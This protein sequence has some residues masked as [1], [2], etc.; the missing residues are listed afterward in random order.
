MSYSYATRC[1][2]PAQELW[3]DGSGKEGAE[4]QQPSSLFLPPTSRHQTSN[5]RVE[6][7]TGDADES[8]EPGSFGGEEADEGSTTRYWGSAE[9][10][11]AN[12]SELPAFL[13]PEA[14]AELGISYSMLFP[15][16]E[17]HSYPIKASLI[18]IS[19]LLPSTLL[20]RAEV[21]LWSRRMLTPEEFRVL[22]GSAFRLE[23][24]ALPKSELTGLYF[25]KHRPCWSVDYYSRQRK[26]KTIDFF[27]P[28]VKHSTLA[29]VLKCASACRL[30][31]PRRFEDVPSWIPEPD[32][33]TGGLPYRAGAAF[34]DSAV[35]KWVLLNRPRGDAP[36]S[37]SES[38]RLNP[39]GNRDV[40]GK[41]G[42]LAF[43]SPRKPGLSIP[44]AVSPSLT[45]DSCSESKVG[46]SPPLV[47]PEAQ[48]PVHGGGSGYPSGAEE[49]LYLPERLVSSDQQK[50]PQLLQQSPPIYQYSGPQQYSPSPGYYDE[51][52]PAPSNHLQIDGREGMPSQGPS[53][54]SSLVGP[55][56]QELPMVKSDHSIS[57]D[58]DWKKEAS[59]KGLAGDSPQ[60]SP[61]AGAPPALFNEGLPAN[62][63]RYPALTDS[64]HRGKRPLERGQKEGR[65]IRKP[66]VLP[67]PVP[68]LDERLLTA[69]GKLEPSGG[70]SD[71]L[72]AGGVGID[73]FTTLP[74][75]PAYHSCFTPNDVSGWGQPIDVLRAWYRAAEG[76]GDEFSGFDTALPECP[77]LAGGGASLPF[78]VTPEDM[79]AAAELASRP[80][81]PT[82]LSGS[83]D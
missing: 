60:A 20:H 46:T 29:L 6:I 15:T 44:L 83:A 55:P 2:V 9:E 48:S 79:A 40:R 61:A 62:G 14:L 31:L 52:S 1:S 12:A 66:A 81:T 58:S 4:Q 51:G 45:C 82:D 7:A 59:S 69:S 78:R 35:L 3:A 72:W 73:P 30:V 22:K 43:D 53:P 42:S 36:Y 26:R 19:S 13:Q 39:R 27:V 10:S 28:D 47:T 38:K 21:H 75:Q 56:S 41:G 71:L 50:Q 5:A 80:Y 65:C 49:F 64:V 63:N 37:S 25:N 54:G 76:D 34:V 77:S 74:R 18:F 8:R 24:D 17:P 70:A 32:E 16:L 57:A 33:S 11:E 67:I 68:R 23:P